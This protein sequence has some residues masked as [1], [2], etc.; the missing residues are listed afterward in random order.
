M[1]SPLTQQTRPE[2]FKPKV[3]QL[4][5]NL[6]QTSDYNEPSEGFW[7]EFFLLPPDRSQ[8]SS[9]LDQLSPDETL[10]LQ[11]QT[12]QLFI[13]AIR[14]AASGA[15][16]VD[17]YALETLMVFLACVLKKKYTN[18]SSD[19]ITVLAGLD[20]VDQVI[21]NFVAVL[22]GIIRNGSSFDLRIKA[23]KTA[24]A[25][26]SG[27]YKTSLVSYFTHRDL[28]PSLMK[29]VQESE[30]P[31]QVFDPFL[32]L[33]LLANYN[34]FEF[35]N[36]YQLRLDDFVNETSIQKI[37]KGVGVSCAAV[38]NGYVAVQ[39]DA[40]EGWTL[41]STLVYFGLGALSPSKKDKA[42][43]PNAEEAKEMFATLPAQQAAILLATYDFTNANK[44]FGHNL[45]SQAPEKD[46]EESPFASFLSLTSYLLH[47]A[48]RSPRIAHYAELNLFTLRILAED[49]TLCKHLC[50]EEN[51]RKIR[52]CRQRQPY[53]PV[54]TGDRVL[55]TVIFDII[56]DTIS[57]NLRRRLDVNI[58]SHS[59]AILLRLLTYLSMNKIRLAYHWS[60]LWRNLLSLMR[61][62]TTYVSD[63]S[64][65]PNITTLTTTLVDLVAFCVSAGDTF[66]P[67]PSSYDDLFYKLVE[68]G[69]IITKYRDVYSLKQSSSKPTDP[70][71]SKDVHVAAVDT[72]ISVSTHFYTLLFNPEQTDAKPDA[73]G[74]GVAPIP[75]H[76]KKNLGPREVHRIIKQGYDTLS[77]QPPEGLSAWTRWRETDAKTELKQAARCVVEDARQLV[78]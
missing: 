14:E 38:R 72:L 53:L 75:A 18:P 44:L 73:D 9:I 17:S 54:V 2:T 19:V 4:Y 3:V 12:Q 68:T 57:H 8:L 76:R 64:S 34:K 59:I 63:L 35:Q 33:G 71:P 20:H 65:N 40:P 66:L 24:I 27:A 22:D 55:A 51:K 39:D 43:P 30:T 29:F 69:P 28:F 52:L 70:N 74:Q 45:I 50:G 49:S 1:E 41:F 61:F 56:I 60:E 77:I 32:L 67:D 21:S 47:H 36:P 23:I 25:M 5:E 15:S 10:N 7:R 31:I 42:S 58:Y 37:V 78:V 46:N 11:V 48:Y 62:L 6:F 16:P 26:T 13:R